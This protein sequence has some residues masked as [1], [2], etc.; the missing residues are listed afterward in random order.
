MSF[1]HYIHG[2]A[3]SPFADHMLAAQRH[4]QLTLDC[5]GYSFFAI[6]FSARFSSNK[7]CGDLFSVVGSLFP[8]HASV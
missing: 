3:G 6:T 8:I 5:R 7:V 1:R 4:Y 2:R